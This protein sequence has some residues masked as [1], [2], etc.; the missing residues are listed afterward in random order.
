MQGGRESHMAFS[1][2]SLS[3]ST[4]RRRPLPLTSNRSCP[5][6]TAP[7]LH[8][9]SPS[10]APKIYFV[11]HRV[12]DLALL[13][14]SQ[15]PL[16]YL[17]D[18]PV[19]SAPRYVSG[20]TPLL[21]FYLSYDVLQPTLFPDPGSLFPVLNKHCTYHLLLY[22]ELGHPMFSFQVFS[23]AP[24][25]WPLSHYRQYALVVHHPFLF[26]DRGS[27]LFIILKCWPH[28]PIPILDPTS[29]ADLNTP[30]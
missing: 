29:F 26:I 11:P 16:C 27:L 28:A 15:Y 20:P 4:A 12:N 9:P 17:G 14:V 8:F 7:V 23:K 18:P 25:F 13:L 1:L 2:L 21:S 6:Q 30:I 5:A 10:F 3:M 19:V 22:G 24:S